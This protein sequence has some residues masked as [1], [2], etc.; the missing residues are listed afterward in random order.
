MNQ[1]LLLAGSKTTMMMWQIAW[2]KDFASWDAGRIST[3]GSICSAVL[4]LDID[5]E[6]FDFFQKESN[7]FF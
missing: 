4:I 7:E 1:D 3:S 2:F 6:G 5:T